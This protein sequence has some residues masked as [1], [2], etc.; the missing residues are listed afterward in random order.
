MG[1]APKITG[2]IGQ[3]AA[4]QIVDYGAPKSKLPN[5]KPQKAPH[6]IHTMSWQLQSHK[7]LQIYTLNVLATPTNFH[8]CNKS[9]T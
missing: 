8:L 2:Q 7:R 5:A 1:V 4:G 6:N 9:D 3:W